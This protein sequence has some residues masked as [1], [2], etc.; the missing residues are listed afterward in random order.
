MQKLNKRLRN[1]S[2]IT[3]IALVIT[4]VILIILAGISIGILFGKNGL[5]NITIKA[6]EKSQIEA[7]RERLVLKLTE[8]QSA[9]I[10]QGKKL[11]L[12][13]LIIINSTENNM[14]VETEIKDE[15]GNEIEERVVIYKEEIDYTKVKVDGYVF[16]VD[17]FFRVEY[18]GGSFGEDPKISLE[19]DKDYEGAEDDDELGDD[20]IILDEE[21]IIDPDVDKIHDTVP[22]G[23]VGIYTEDDLINMKNDL[24]KKYILMA[25]ITL[26][27]NWTPLGDAKTEFTGYLNG[28]GYTITKMNISGTS[29]YL[30]MFARTSGTACITN[31]TLKDSTVTGSGKYIGS[32]IGYNKGNIRGVSIAGNTN[33]NINSTATYVGGL[34]GYHRYYSKTTTGIERC[35]T[36]GTIT[37]SAEYTGGI[38]GLMQGYSSSYVNSTYIANS[39]ST[40]KVK[41][42]AKVGG[43]VRN[44]EI[45]QIKKYLHNRKNNRNK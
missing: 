21:R 1:K 23:W 40:M 2:G 27:K 41:G 25:D 18:I 11:R 5:V 34:V 37:S 36:G 43:I 9:A 3:L 45:F 19:K 20:G 13:D 15:E 42:E 16:K 38:V 31:L 14:V 29:G 28:N 6:R 8:L 32:L 12:E 22:G 24:S 44:N 35:Y 30:G 10:E 39:Y 26:T 4:I 7:A 33:I 17:E